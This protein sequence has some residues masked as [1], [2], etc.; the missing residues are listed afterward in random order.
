MYILW[1]VNNDLLFFKEMSISLLTVSWNLYLSWREWMLQELISAWY[2]ISYRYSNLLC[3]FGNSFIS[4][5][6]ETINTESAQLSLSK[7][8]VLGIEP[9]IFVCSTNEVIIQ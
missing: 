4:S 6:I 8:T 9:S 5:I 7:V 2:G 3:E 1:N